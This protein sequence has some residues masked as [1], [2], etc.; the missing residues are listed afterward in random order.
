MRGDTFLGLVSRVRLMGFA[1]QAR[2]GR[3]QGPHSSRCAC[4]CTSLEG[5]CSPPPPSMVM[6]W[7]TVSMA[8]AKLS[9]LVMPCLGPSQP[10]LHTVPFWHCRPWPVSRAQGEGSSSAGTSQVA[11]GRDTEAGW[12]RGMGRERREKLVKQW[13]GWQRTQQRQHRAQSHQRPEHKRTHT[14]LGVHSGCRQFRR[15]ALSA[16]CCKTVFNLD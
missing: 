7:N 8:K 11:R 3:N 4:D 13:L 5:G 14:A 6:H 16:E 10:G 9:K 1:S 2:P 12:G 15:S